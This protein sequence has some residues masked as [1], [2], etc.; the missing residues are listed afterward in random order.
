MT[1]IAPNWR[2]S[3]TFNMMFNISWF[4]CIGECSACVCVLTHKPSCKYSKCFIAEQYNYILP[5]VRWRRRQFH[6]VNGIIVCHPFKN[7]PRDRPTISLDLLEYVSRSVLQAHLARDEIMRYLTLCRRTTSSGFTY[8]H[9]VHSRTS[10]HAFALVCVT[11]S[12][13]NL[14]SET[15]ISV[16]PSRAY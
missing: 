4:T 13:S 12:S 8:L 14:S 7:L 2:R 5:D 11:H 6:D 1:T 16:I 10:T 3:I 15:V 9:I